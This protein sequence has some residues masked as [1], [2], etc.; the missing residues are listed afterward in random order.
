MIRITA[1]PA[2]GFYRCG[3]YHPPTPIDHAEERFTD[4]ELARLR[5]E[6][7]L[8]VEI[9][10]GASAGESEREQQLKAAMRKVMEGKQKSDF[11]KDGKPTTEAIERE[12]PGRDITAAERDAW[13]KELYPD[14]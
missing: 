7:H 4:E 8:V 14:A 11:T 9:V 1:K 12:A 3:V 5:S 10:E 2:R 13:F 6:P